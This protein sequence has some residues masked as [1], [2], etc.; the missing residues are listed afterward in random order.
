ME[1]DV[2]MVRRIFLLEKTMFWGCF[3][4]TGLNSIFHLYL[5][6]DILDRSSLRDSNEELESQITKKKVWHLKL[7]P[8]VNHRINKYR[9]RIIR[10]LKLNLAEH[11]P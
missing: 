3:E 7:V 9:I 6:C 2:T 4:A 5:Y 8:L 1:V 11:Q 10:V